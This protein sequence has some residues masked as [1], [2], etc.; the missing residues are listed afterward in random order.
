MPKRVAGLL[1]LPTLLLAAGLGAQVPW[2]TPFLMPPTG[3]QG[4]GIHLLDFSPGGL[5]AQFT[6]RRG[7]LP[8]GMGLRAGLAE[9]PVS[10]DLSFMGGVD[11]AGSLV[12]ASE[13][14]PLEVTWVLGAGA[15]IGSEILLSFPAGVS[16][17]AVVEGEGVRLVPYATPRLVMDVFTGGGD[18]LD[19]SF[20]VDVGLNLSFDASWDVRFGASLGDREAVAV[21]IGVPLR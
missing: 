19:L 7:S 11:L 17:G 1:T 16:V 4:L 10:G 18:N 15:G 13:D 21:G 6:Y 20:A 8:A 3:G 14:V 5:G 12:A 2:E 9:E